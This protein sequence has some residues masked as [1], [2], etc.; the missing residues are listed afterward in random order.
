M[1]TRK[2]GRRVDSRLVNHHRHPILTMIPPGAVEP[3]R[4]RAVHRNCEGRVPAILVRDGHK[5]APDAGFV[6]DAGL[7]EGALG[8]RVG[9]GVEGEFERVACGGGH[10]FGVE[11]E[12]AF[13]D[14]DGCGFG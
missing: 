2:G 9:L 11:F 7:C 3:Q 13:A 4:L 6:R 14:G 5:V 1:K 10:C 12:A 8:N